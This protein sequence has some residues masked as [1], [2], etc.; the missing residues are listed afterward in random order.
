MAT[1][2]TAMALVY[3][4]GQRIASGEWGVLSDDADLLPSPTPSSWP[5]PVG[6]RPLTRNSAGH[7][8]IVVKKLEM[9]GLSLRFQE[10]RLAGEVLR[11]SSSRA[12]ETSPVTCNC[13]SLSNSM[14]AWR[15]ASP[16]W[17]SIGPGE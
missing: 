10:T 16:T 2:A 13:R 3:D 9:A 7:P 12:G 6:P 8:G 1:F 4:S 14:I 15:V 17:P 11:S 5:A